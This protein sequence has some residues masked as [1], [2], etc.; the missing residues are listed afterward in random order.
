MNA[1]YLR[2]RSKVLLPEGAGATPL[3]VLA[4]LQKNLESLGFLLS[5]DVTEWL[6][7]LSLVQIEAFYQR[8]VKDFAVDRGVTPFDLERIAA[9]FM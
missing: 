6:K 4:S 2:R 3:N 1:I 5:A 8:L 9:D 7:T